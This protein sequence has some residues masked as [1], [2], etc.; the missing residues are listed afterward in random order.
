MILEITELNGLDM[1]FFLDFLAGVLAGDEVA[2]LALGAVLRVSDLEELAV[3]D[4]RL[5]AAEGVLVERVA[6]LA[7]VALEVHLADLAAFVGAELVVVAGSVLGDDRV[8][9]GRAVRGLA[10]A[11]RALGVLAL[12]ALASHQPP[13]ELAN[14]AGALAHV[15]ETAVQFL[16]RCHA[17][18][19]VL[20]ETVVAGQALTVHAETAERVVGTAEESAEENKSDQEFHL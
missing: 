5:F 13:A 6:G 20:G 19:V 16:G 2:S 15:V 4:L 17:F 12:R 18:P 1:D 3:G 7:D 8:G 11:G 10:V 14:R 9:A